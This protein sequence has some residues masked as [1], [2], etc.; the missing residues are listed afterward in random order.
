MAERRDGEAKK[1]TMITK[2]PNCGHWQ[3]DKGK[4][5]S[6]GQDVLGH[7]ASKLGSIAAGALIGSS[8]PVIGTIAGG[9]AG[10][11]FSNKV[12][13][14]LF[15]ETQYKFVCSQCG[16]KFTDNVSSLATRQFFKENENSELRIRLSVAFVDSKFMKLEDLRVNNSL[17]SSKIN[18]DKLYRQIETEFGITFTYSVR[19][20]LKKKS[21]KIIDLFENILSF[22]ESHE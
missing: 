9:I 19:E 17:S 2:C 11:L 5:T 12:D 14:L 3:S 21:A 18:Y 16:C 10:A 20:S 13:N 7:G 4:D 22:I 6:F 8:I 15:G 1:I